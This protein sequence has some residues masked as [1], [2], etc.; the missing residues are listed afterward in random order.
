MKKLSFVVIAVFISAAAL[1]SVFAG[2]PQSRVKHTLP[3][4]GTTFINTYYATDSAGHI[5]PKDS[6]DPRMPDDTV[7][8]ALSGQTLHGRPNT[9]A[10]TAR[11]HGDTTFLSYATN[12]DL[13]I[14]NTGKSHKWERLT[15]GT[16]PGKMSHTSAKLDSGHVM[17]NYYA[18]YKHDELQVIGWDTL[19]VGGISTPTIRL[20]I[21]S[22]MSY[23]KKRMHGH[24]PEEE[25][26]NATNYWY[27]PS[28]GYFAR[29]N[30]GWD[31][32]YFL[33]QELKEIRMSELGS[34]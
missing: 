12:G 3:R 14:L 33:N 13:W 30:F 34:K 7:D 8:V 6:T 10:I 21:V 19:R 9:V 22:V 16:Q 29:I 31:S 20:R 18:L 32:K 2:A 25:Y 27:A 24:A 1:T 26:R 15:F 5:P 4:T 23:D 11:A 28:L 17:G